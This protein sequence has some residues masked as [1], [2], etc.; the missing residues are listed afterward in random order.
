MAANKTVLR[1]EADSL[2]WHGVTSS[3]VDRVAY[4]ADFAR[5]YV[6]F[7]SSLYVYHDVPPSVFADF[8]AAPSKGKFVHR[9]IRNNGADDRYPYDPLD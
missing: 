6:K 8:L 1:A 5:L 9:E 2:D 7:K 3:N 4:S